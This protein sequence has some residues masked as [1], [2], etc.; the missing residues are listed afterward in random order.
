[1]Y[2]RVIKWK[3]PLFESSSP[4]HLLVLETLQ[5]SES[6]PEFFELRG[7]RT[8]RRRHSLRNL[9]MINDRLAAHSFKQQTFPREKILYIRNERSKRVFLYLPFKITFRPRAESHLASAWHFSNPATFFILN[10]CSNPLSFS[11]ISVYLLILLDKSLR[12][13][14]LFIRAFE[15]NLVE[16]SLRYPFLRTNLISSN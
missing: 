11:F 13:N 3:N 16:Y 14:P 8:V 9:A 15:S 7:P 2:C 12:G 6:S 5:F 4:D 10:V 1:M